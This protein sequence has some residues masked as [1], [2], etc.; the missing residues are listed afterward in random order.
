MFRHTRHPSDES[1]LRGIDGELPPRLSTAL[2]THLAAC[3]QCRT[4]QQTIRSSSESA[5]GACVDESTAAAPAL[6]EVRTRLRAS[7]ARRSAELDRSW[8]FQFVRQATRVPPATL[9]LAALILFIVGV[10]VGRHE[11]GR[12]PATV[13]AASIEEGALPIR[14]LTPGATARVT[15]DQLCA[16]RGPGH[17]PIAPEVRQAV[18]RDYGMEGLAEAEYELDYLITPELGGSSD[19]RNLWPERYQSRVW[20]ALVKDELER[21]LPTLV[22]RGA[23][24]L[25]TAQ[26]DIASNWIAAYKKYFRTDRPVATQARATAEDRMR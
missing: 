24:D 7:L 20:N 12:L 1:L 5:F 14:A 8:R 3:D 6:E 15:A 2:E 10:Y 17:E 23:I 4:R 26:R 21:L 22:C 11:R 18:L 16:G 13:S 25:A 9:G 19:R